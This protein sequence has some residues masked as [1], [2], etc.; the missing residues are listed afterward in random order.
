MLL[1]RLNDGINDCD[2]RREVNVTSDNW[3]NMNLSYCYSPDKTRR[4]PC[5]FIDMKYYL[6]DDYKEPIYIQGKNGT[7]DY[8]YYP[9]HPEL[10]YVN[11]S[12]NSS[13]YVYY[14]CNNG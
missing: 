12:S 3:E 1:N 6:G 7:L 8:F 2:K 14:G 10:Y 13:F 9:E 4:V 11:V 5:T